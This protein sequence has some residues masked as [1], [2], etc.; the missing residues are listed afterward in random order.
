MRYE[1]FARLAEDVVRDGVADKA[2]VV[3][4][5]YVYELGEVGVEGFFVEAHGLGDFDLVYGEEG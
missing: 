1:A 4:D 2:I 3:Y 5:V